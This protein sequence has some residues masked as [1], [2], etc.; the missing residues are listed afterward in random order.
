VAGS[1]TDA[2]AQ[3]DV[4]A[5]AN[6]PFMWFSGSSPDIIPHL[7]RAR[8]FLSKPFV[9]TTLLTAVTGLLKIP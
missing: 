4:L 6:V 2:D 1:L 5:S 7:H 9:P 8:P 3:P